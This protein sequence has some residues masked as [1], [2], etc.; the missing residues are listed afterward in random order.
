MLDRMLVARSEELR[1][2]TR[3]LNDGLLLRLAGGLA[4]ADRL[5]LIP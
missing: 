2:R 1:E 4:L 5:P 3:D